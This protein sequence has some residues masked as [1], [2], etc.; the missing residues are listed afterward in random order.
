M[1][2]VLKN[3]QGEADYFN[4]LPATCPAGDALERQLGD[5]EEASLKEAIVYLR[6]GACTPPPVVDPA[7]P[8]SARRVRS[9][10]QPTDGW[11]QLLG[12]Q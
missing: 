7:A 5:V 1:S 9:A 12:A 10:V 6:T 8:A 11:Q 3:A 4:G 2:F